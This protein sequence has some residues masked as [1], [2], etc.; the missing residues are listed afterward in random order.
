MYL[1]FLEINSYHVT[2]LEI[3]SGF[4]I[5]IVRTA[6]SPDIISKLISLTVLNED[7]SL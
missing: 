7:D 5:S 1:C 4:L 3:L 6:S 2:F